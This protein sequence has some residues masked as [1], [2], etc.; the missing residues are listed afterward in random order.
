MKLLQNISKK[1][2]S[3]PLIDEWDP[4]LDVSDE[5]VVRDGVDK[6]LVNVKH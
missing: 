5:A 2:M 3:T 4:Q 6:V 1:K